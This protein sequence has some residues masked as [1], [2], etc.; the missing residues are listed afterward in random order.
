MKIKILYLKINPSVSTL[1]YSGKST[2]A[3]GVGLT[4]SLK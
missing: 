4:L 3:K 1:A 2:F